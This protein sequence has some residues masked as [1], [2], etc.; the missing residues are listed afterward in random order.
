MDGKNCSD[1]T[2]IVKINGYKFFELKNLLKKKVQNKQN[3]ILC[4]PAIKTESV[5]VLSNEIKMAK[6][7][8]NIGFLDI[9]AVAYDGEKDD[10]IPKMARRIGVTLVMTREVGTKDMNKGVLGTKGKGTNMR[11]F[12]Y[13]AIKNL[14][15][16][17]LKNN[18]VGFLDADISEKAFGEHYILGLFGPL[19]SKPSKIRLV[20][21]VYR[22]PKGFGRV[23][24]LL[25]HPLMSV[26]DHP[27]LKVLQFIPYITSGEVAMD[28]KL[29]AEL[30]FSTGY[31][32]EVYTLMQF[33]LDK[34]FGSSKLELT[35][36]GFFD[37]KHQR[38]DDLRFMSFSIL[39]VFFRTLKE[40]KLLSFKNGTAISN[41]F[42][43]SGVS[44]PGYQI[45]HTYK[46]LDNK[47]YRP[48]K[49]M[50]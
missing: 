2:G 34:R 14:F 41:T 16:G 9:I 29:I 25:C 47:T 11:K 6:R 45:Q 1:K 46:K 5:K 17:K 43:S 38:F 12:S 8:Q 4:F 42:R 30:K 31:S 7:L 39:R 36:V 32:A 49:E 13:F 15:K 40:Y 18:L 50:I 19:I 23:N 44:P 3:I 20:K 37:H 26:I 28:G 24:K 21:L 27:K 33:V 48:L 10:P 35:N 22:R